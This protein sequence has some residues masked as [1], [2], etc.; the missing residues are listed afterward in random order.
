MEGGNTPGVDDIFVDAD[1]VLVAGEDFA[2]DAGGEAAAVIAVELLLQLDAVGGEVA[3]VHAAGAGEDIESVAAEEVL[4]F[5]VDVAEAGD[6]CAAAHQLRVDLPSRASGT[7][8][9]MPAP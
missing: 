9:A 2:H 8:Q 3:R 1:V 7:E 5:G 4:C 6:E